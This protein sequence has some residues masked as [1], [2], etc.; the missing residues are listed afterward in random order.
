MKI[1]LAVDGSECAVRATRKLVEMSAALKEPPGVELVTVQLPVPHVGGFSG[2]VISQDMIESHYRAEGEKALA[3]SVRVLQEAKVAYTPHILV[4]EIARAI[5]EEGE[6]RGCELIC[7]GTRGMGAASS[8]LIGSI[9]IKVL[10]R[11]RIPVT[12][13]P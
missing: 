10:H 9:G 11:A 6:K 13:V 5:V 4:G 1:L 2:K 7:M 12:L 3:P 8:M